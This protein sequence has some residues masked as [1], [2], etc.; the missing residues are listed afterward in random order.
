MDGYPTDKSRVK[1]L[2]QDGNRGCLNSQPLFIFS[3]IISRDKFLI[4]NL[5]CLITKGLPIQRIELTYK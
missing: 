2:S 3:R 4:I 1:L 5:G